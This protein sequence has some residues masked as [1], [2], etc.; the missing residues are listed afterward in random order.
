MKQKILFGY[1]STKAL[2]KII[3]LNRPR[4]IFLITDRN[5][6]TISGAENA[7]SGVIQK[8]HYVHFYDFEVNPKIE[9]IQ[10]GIAFFKKEKCDFIIGV[11]GGSIID[12]AKAISIL[13]SN[14]GEI[15]S[16]IRNGKALRNRE[17]PTAVIPTTAGTGSESTHFSVVYI[18][19]TKYSLAH[20]SIIPDYVILDP[21][22]TESLPPYITATT[23]MDA[24]SQAIESYW[25][26]QSTNKSR[27][28]SRE[29]IQIIMPNLVKAVQNPDRHSRKNMLKGSNLA[30]KAINISKTTAAHSVSYPITSFFHIAHGHAVSLTLPYFIQLNE[31]VD[32]KNIQDSRGVSF[33]K[34]R[35][36]EILKLLG[37]GT[38]VEAKTMM[39]HMM[40]EIGL[41]TNLAKLGIGEDDIEIIVKNGFHPQRMTN[42]PRSISESELRDLLRKIR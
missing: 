15:D 17:I 27:G 34:Q 26:T 8:Y 18:G 1:H 14:N 30:G 31:D 16:Y 29:A 5:S 22:L 28:F 41:E 25:S 39:I 21:T 12:T 9:D 7:L 3:R 4:K 24:L 35:M 23:G 19:K 13:V 40:H 6:F 42:N 11:G 38:S 32:S 37:V 20:D 36:H 33:V 2:D 10:K